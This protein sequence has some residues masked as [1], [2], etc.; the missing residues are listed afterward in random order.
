M[1]L[2]INSIQRTQTVSKYQ[3]LSRLG[4]SAPIKQQ[5]ADE[6][7]L[8]ESARLFKTLLQTAKDLPEINTAKIAAL[9]EQIDTGNYTPDSRA[10]AEK[11]LGYRV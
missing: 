2:K 7:D 11:M 3:S 1:D 9:K 10:I 6:V 4:V 8:S 5:P